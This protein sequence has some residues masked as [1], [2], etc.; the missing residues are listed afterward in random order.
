[1]H[2]DTARK[3]PMNDFMEVQVKGL[4]TLARLDTLCD[5]GVITPP[6]HIHPKMVQTFGQMK[7]LSGLSV[8]L[9]AFSRCNSRDHLW[10]RS[11]ISFEQTCRSSAIRD[12]HPP[13][14]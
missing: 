2:R 10:R 4:A 1:M 8:R 11:G 3:A 14:T 13:W 12:N 9:F 7:V 5:D 6:R